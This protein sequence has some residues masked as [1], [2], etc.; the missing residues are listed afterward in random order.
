[1]RQLEDVEVVAGEQGEDAVEAGE[2][3]DGEG[4]GYEFCCG[5]EGDYVE[6]GLS[7][8]SRVAHRGGG[9]SGLP[10]GVGSGGGRAWLAI[11]G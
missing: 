7:S 11:G 9:R 4:E 5:G 8:I 6:E 2:F 3:V 1:M 10:W